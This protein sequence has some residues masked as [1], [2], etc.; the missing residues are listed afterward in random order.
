M[1]GGAAVAYLRGRWSNSRSINLTASWTSVSRLELA[2][3]Y[4]AKNNQTFGDGEFGQTRHAVD[5]QLAHD[6]LAVRFH[7]ANTD[8]ERV[9][10]FFIAKAL[11]D[12]NQNFPL[13]IGRLRGGRSFTGA[14]DEFVQCHARDLRAEKGFAGIDR[15]DGAH[16]FLQRG[17]FEHIAARSGL[18]DAPDIFGIAVHREDEHFDGG[19]FTPQD[20][21][22]LQAV[23]EG[24]VDVH[25]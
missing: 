19:K 9:G 5:I 24:H 16:Q 21:G 3:V 12:V 25:E 4:I 23:H 13:A 11:G 8:P 10:D 20:L 17:F 15:F 22:D 18:D 2:R 7:G 1:E 6:V 14:A